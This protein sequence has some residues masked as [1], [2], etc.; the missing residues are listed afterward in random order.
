MDFDDLTIAGLHEFL[1]GDYIQSELTF[2]K[3]SELEP[4]DSTTLVH[5]A[6]AQ[7]QLKKYEL[8]EGV[9]KRSIEIDP[10]NFLAWFR[11]GQS[12][13]SCQRAKEAVEAFGQAIA[14]KSDYADAWFMGG[15]ALLLDGCVNDGMTALKNAVNLQPGSAIFNEVLAKNFLAYKKEI[16]TLIISGGIGDILLCLPFLLENRDQELKVRVYSHFK[17]AEQLFSYL[18]IPIE[19]F[20]YF[21]NEHERQSLQ[22]EINLIRESYS[23]PKRWFMDQNPFTSKQMELDSRRQTIGIQLG[24]SAISIAGQTRLGIPAKALP[25][26]LLKVLFEANKFNIVLFGSKDE[27]GSYSLEENTHLK[28]AH[29]DNIDESLSLVSQCDYFVGSDSSIK[30]LAAMLQIPSLVWLGDYQDQYRD[31]VFI[32]PYTRLKVMDLFKYKNLEND[33]SLGI[34]SIENFLRIDGLNTGNKIIN[35]P[36][37]QFNEGSA[38]K[39][40]WFDNFPNGRFANAVFQYIFAKYIEETTDFEVIIGSPHKNITEFPWILFD[41]PNHFERIHQFQAKQNISSMLLGGNRCDSPEKDKEKIVTYF[42]SSG[43]VAL[44]VDGYF[45]YDTQQIKSLP[46]Y[47]KIFKKYIST[48]SNPVTPFQYFIKNSQRYLRKKIGDKTLISI[49]VRLGDYLHFTNCGDWRQEVFY[50][51][52]LEKILDKVCEYLVNNRINNSVIYIASDDLPYC[53]KFFDAKGISIV[54]NEDILKTEYQTEFN[55]LMMDVAALSSSE[56]LIGSNSSLSI[57]SSLINEQGRVFWRPMSNGDIS[58]FDPWS[59]PILY[60]P[61]PDIKDTDPSTYRNK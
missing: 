30:A 23:C 38:K 35:F 42:Q 14:I 45:Q 12:Y 37:K 13:Y 34:K 60:G 21:S 8:A 61:V 5:L 58:S 2:I 3:A 39:V 27:I 56:L 40:V 53:K 29:F 6:S 33:F 47:R 10:K 4:N 22:E 48:N 16:G 26:S 51:I 18:S 7:I 46:E 31:Q 57:L 20:T 55:I 41:L 25:I 11:L 32:E 15:Q 1:H 44:K 28:F 54:T 49:H 36:Q 59:T 52:N 19:K 24:G 50:P 9:L 17:G 43:Q